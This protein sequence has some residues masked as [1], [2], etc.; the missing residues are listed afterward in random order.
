MVIN[1]PGDAQWKPPAVSA[2]LIEV[3]GRFAPPESTP[4]AGR[5]SQIASTRRQCLASAETHQ[6][7]VQINM[8]KI[9]RN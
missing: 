2:G 7:R 4:I 1:K 3:L 8:K 5:E 9:Q 6:A